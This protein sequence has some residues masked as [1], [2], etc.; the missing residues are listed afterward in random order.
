METAETYT[1]KWVDCPYCGMGCKLDHD[2]VDYNQQ[3]FLCGE[4]EK[5]FIILD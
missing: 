3:N 1:I 4:C 2:E 5:T